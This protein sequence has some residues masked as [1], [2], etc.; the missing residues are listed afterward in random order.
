MQTK[1]WTAVLV[2]L[3]GAAV[4]TSA[5][6]AKGGRAPGGG[7]PVIASP[8]PF[9]GPVTFT[10]PANTHG[11]NVIG[12]VQD[13]TVSGINCPGLPAS[14]Q[15]GTVTV[16]GLTIT[17]P[18]NITMQMPAA[19][20]TWADLF[21]PAKF[22]AQGTPG[23]FKLNSSSSGPGITGQPFPSMEISVIGN[24]VNGEYIA[25]LILISEQSVNT[26]NGY[27]VAIDYPNGVLLVSDRPNGDAAV[28][29]Q[30]N[31]PNGRF[32]AGTAVQSPDTRFAVDD[33]NPTIRS[34]S[35]YPMCIPRT[36]PAKDDDK[37]CPKRNRPI[38]DAAGNGCRS[39]RQAGVVLL[40]GR[41]FHAAVPG[42]PC[43][44]FVMPDPAKALSTEPTSFEQVP[45]AIGD[46]I[47]FSG[48][49][50]RGDH[51]GPGGSDTISAHTIEAN[52]GVFTQPGTLPVYIAIGQFGL[53]S[54]TPLT[55]NGTVPQE[56]PDRIFLEAN[57]TDVTSIVDIYLM[58]ADLAIA[59]KIAN[60]WI[61]PATMTGGTGA[62]GSNGQLIDGG[63][64]TQ[65]VGPV[66]GRARI[67]ANKATPGVL[68]SP[69]RYVR[70]AVRSL[71]D[72]A[73][74]NGKADLL[75]SPGTKV[76]C[77]ERAVAA[78]GIQTGQ[79]FA[80]VFTY[81]FPGNV[82]PGDPIVPNDLW[83]FDF[84]VHGEGPGTGP[85]IP[86]PW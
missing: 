11:F 16:N 15:G 48:T 13:A 14:Q 22:T 31:D 60:R 43:T 55:F 47:I 8:P 50:I 81:L 56:P 68:T 28:R 61:T 3:L 18:C 34:S 84:L 70:V 40:T 74:I 46:H 4:A 62:V 85:L 86:S 51:K 23:S 25:G 57:V 69:T 63:I 37:L 2:F 52:V 71:C 39:F 36:D 9:I 44:G 72:P 58:D 21:N 49:L 45:F 73:N 54:D 59:G 80:P 77:L 24:I 38:A 5:A 75:G 29:V 32:S 67:R 10:N 12:F 6:E 20:F 27:I 41:D 66:P 53:S 30:I 83:D 1:Y 33:Q 19:T 78:H 76:N 65:F 82:V 26:S 42:K 35:G 17:V 64:T 7:A 79:Y